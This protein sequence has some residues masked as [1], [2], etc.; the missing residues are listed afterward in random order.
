MPFLGDQQYFVQ[1]PNGTNPP[2]T[3]WGNGDFNYDEVI[4]GSD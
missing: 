1:H 4:D 3:G 2:Y